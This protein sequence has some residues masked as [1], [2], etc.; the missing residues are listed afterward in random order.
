MTRLL[1][2]FGDSN[3]HGTPPIVVPG[4]YERFAEDTRWPQV[5]L[6]ALGPDWRLAEEGLPGRTTCFAD[7][8]M[9][10]H[11]E[12]S[13]GLKIALQS[14]GPID[15][16][17]LMLG[18]NDCKT[19][20]GASAERIAAGVAGLLD[21]ALGVEMQTRHGG[22]KVLLM[23]PPTILEQGPIADQFFGAVEKSAALAGALRKLAAARGIAFLDT[24]ALIRSSPTD[25]V[26]FEPDAHRLLGA[27]V[28]RAVTAL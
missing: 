12:G 8:V 9:G 21:I 4:R 14:H 26:H 25:G 17:T 19:R 15:A 22:F 23:A 18:T 7:P 16:M 20:Y 24:G 28:A 11:M 10:S 3:T 2:C 13:E 5:A 1:L 27:A 6:A